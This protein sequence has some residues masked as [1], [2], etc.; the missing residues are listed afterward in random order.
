MPEQCAS[1]PAVDFSSALYPGS[2]KNYPTWEIVLKISFVVLVEIVAIVGNILLILIVMGSKKM[3]TTTNYYIVN[4]AISDL[5]VA[6]F[7]IWMHLVDDVTEGWVVGGFLCKFNPFMQITVM[8]ASVFTLMALAGDRFFA[9]MFPLKSRVTQRKVSYIIVFVWIWSLAVG[10]PVL[11]VYAYSERQWKNFL[12]RFCTDIW[13]QSV[14]SDG[15]CDRGLTSKRAYWT[16]VIVV[17]N[18]VPMVM[19]MISYTVILVKLYQNRIVPSS[20]ALS[21]SA[22]QQRSK[23]KVIKMLFAILLIFVV[24]TIPFQISK[25]FELYRNDHVNKERLP[26]WYNPFYFAAVTL[27]YTNSALN[28]II[29]GGL[30]ENFR[31]AFKNMINRRNS[32]RNDSHYSLRNGITRPSIINNSLYDNG[33]RRDS[34]L[35]FLNDIH[36][37]SQETAQN[38]YL[39][40]AAS[41]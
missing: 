31:T 8:C 29:Y 40:E 14:M 6:L 7:P 28:P 15:E 10:A 37:E 3:R 17:L 12:E 13:P 30:N 34:K 19:M 41:L 11:F 5:L 25:L 39:N 32:S 2:Y 20:G 27:L 26:D 38:G 33:S 35:Q 1:L 4:L 21:V 23:K 36:K 24:C 16:L 18:W 22:I 9:I